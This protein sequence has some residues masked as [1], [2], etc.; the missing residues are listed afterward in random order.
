MFLVLIIYNLEMKED[1]TNIVK[2]VNFQSIIHTEGTGKLHQSDPKQDNA[3]WPGRIGLT[4]LSISIKEDIETLKE[5][6][7]IFNDKVIDKNELI[8]IYSWISDLK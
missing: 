3:V 4:H 2:A 8:E 6:I 5:K 7:C 1:V